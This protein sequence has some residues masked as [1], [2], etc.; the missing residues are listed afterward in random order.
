MRRM[1]RMSFSCGMPPTIIQQLAKVARVEHRELTVVQ[2]CDISRT[3]PAAE[4][5]HFPKDIARP[6]FDLP[7][8]D[9]DLDLAFRDEIDTV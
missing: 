3:W 6:E 2:R 4:Q 1:E 7:S 9:R 5:R 8:G